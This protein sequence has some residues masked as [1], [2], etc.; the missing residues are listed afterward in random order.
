MEDSFLVYSFYKLYCLF[1]THIL[2]LL[3]FHSN[4]IVIYII[5]T[6]K[7]SIHMSDNSYI[8]ISFNIIVWICLQLLDWYENLTHIHN[9]SKQSRVLL[10]TC[11]LPFI[12]CL[13]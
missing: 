5:Y 6:W 1:F 13:N 12:S 10:F 4:I 3:F 8:Q 2:K 11:K 9:F 7:N